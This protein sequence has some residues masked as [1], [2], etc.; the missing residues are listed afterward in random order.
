MQMVQKESADRVI[1][2]DNIRYASEINI[3]AGSCVFLS[4]GCLFW[5]F[6]RK[7]KKEN[8][9]RIDGRLIQKEEMEP[10]SLWGWAIAFDNIGIF[11][12]YMNQT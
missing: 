6:Y 2:F 4:V 12:T 11:I 10:L 3:I 9:D 7:I 1:F 5:V 8:Q